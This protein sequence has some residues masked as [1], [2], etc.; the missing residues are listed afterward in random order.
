MKLSPTRWTWTFLGSAALLSLI[1]CGGGGGNNTPPPPPPP[2]NVTVTL[3]PFQTRLLPKGQQ[4]FTATVEGSTNTAVTWSLQESTTAG[5]ISTTGDYQAP[6]ALGTFHVV[7][8]SV[9][10]TACHGSAL[11]QVSRFSEELGP[12]SDHGN[13]AAV[14]LLDGRIL[15]VGG[16]GSAKGE[17]FD[18]GIQTF[19]PVGDM[20]VVRVGH[21]A[22]LLPN[23][24]VLV[25]GGLGLKSAELFDP[26]S[27]T[28]AK[29]PDMA[30]ERYKH[31]A[32]LLR[33]G[34]VLLVGS[35]QSQGDLVT[36]LF[37]P[38][39]NHFTRTGDLTNSRS[40]PTATL[41]ADGHVLLSGG[42][43]D[44]RPSS[45]L[46][47]AELYDPATGH[48][49]PTGSMQGPRGNH[50]STLLPNGKVLI[51]GGVDDTFNSVATAE[52]FD[53]THGVF[54][55]I[56][57]MPSK[58]DSHA[59]TLLP[60]GTL[61][62]IGGW[63]T[64]T[65]SN[66]S[67]SSST[68]NGLLTFC[69][70]NPAMETFSAG[71]E[72]I[73]E[74]L[75]GSA[76]LYVDSPDSL[77]WA[78]G[79]TTQI[80]YHFP[81]SSTGIQVLLPFQSVSMPPSGCLLASA[82]VTGATDT[83]VT[84][85]LQ[86]GSSGGTVSA[87]GLYT[88]P[89]TAGTYHLVATSLQD[90][91]KKGTLAIQV[92]PTGVTV[93]ITPVNAYLLTQREITLTAKVNGVPS[94]EV[95]WKVKEGDSGGTIDGTGKY[96]APATA[97]TYHI[98][99]TSLW[100][101]SV[102]SIATI[103]VAASSGYASITMPKPL[104]SLSAVP[105]LDDNVL[106][107]GGGSA[108]DTFGTDQVSNQAF[109]FQ[110]STGTFSSAGT[111]NTPR[112]NHTGILLPTGQV[113]LSGGQATG[114]YYAPSLNTCETYTLGSGFTSAPPL[115]DA[116]TNHMTLPL[117]DGRFFLWGRGVYM[118]GAPQHLDPTTGALLAITGDTNVSVKASGTLLQD[119][120]VLLAG[121]G[122]G[123][124]L[125]DPDT[126]SMKNIAPD[127][128]WSDTTGVCLS[129]GRVLLLQPTRADLFDP[130]TK[131]FT[132]TGSPLTT[133]VRCRATLLPNGKVLITGGYNPATYKG[134][135]LTELY[136]PDAGL[137]S[138]AGELPTGR[139]M[140]TPVLLSNGKVAIFGGTQAYGTDYGSVGLVD[141]CIFDTP[142]PATPQVT[143]LP[144]AIRVNPSKSAI[145]R[146]IVMGTPNLALSWTIQEG[147]IGGSITSQ[148]IYTAPANPGIYHV[149]ATC[150]ADGTHSSSATIL[151]Q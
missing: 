24:K 3:T 36:E 82:V 136:D 81:A 69:H 6:D 35:T 44:A 14:R 22:T 51:A 96:T 47:T 79:G 48:W 108:P 127:S 99:A 57:S 5:S 64:T 78:F 141:V 83:R 100:D 7:A 66:G 77:P 9:A 26:N 89:A 59:V 41:L 116:W 121:E 12:L 143:V 60:D 73:P 55:A 138:S 105:L 11:V 56:A 34:K 103:E 2:P 112:Y 132:Q 74:V 94:P 65:T 142:T 97:G 93:D 84:W 38:E 28:F 85:T 32:I 40:Q 27:G 148:G 92:V 50:S 80:V 67:S 118:W 107:T 149:V 123:A 135:A 71:D 76:S 101:P 30:V 114:G 72:K 53:P 15:L 61:M 8:T 25:T 144:Q 87:K 43:Q 45:P 113:Y 104:H 29:L 19:T 16:S 91:T 90:P 140:H 37:D 151:V 88:A 124:F 134:I 102:Q 133:R 146:G 139:Y 68:S 95:E 58:R 52:C 33:T 75:Q 131:T 86:E 119:G 62:L 147:S 13:G 39:T 126:G 129:D 31:A 115:S 17:F 128:N 20:S 122:P 110:P 54:A 145:L 109:L 21:T 125:F 120:R 117:P 130:G 4:P 42:F 63:N 10:N 111:L 23:G 49:T 106:L 1:S 70:F 46:A 98:V 150:Q 18:P 137:F